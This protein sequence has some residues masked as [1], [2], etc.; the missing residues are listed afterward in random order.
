MLQRF[1]RNHISSAPICTS[2]LGYQSSRR[3]HLSK[4]HYDGSNVF[5]NSRVQS[6]AFRGKLF[7]RR[8]SGSKDDG[9]K[10]LEVKERHPTPDATLK[11]L[12]FFGTSPVVCCEETATVI[13]VFGTMNRVR[14]TALPAQNKSGTITGILT[15]RDIRMLTKETLSD[16]LLP[17]KDFL[18]KYRNE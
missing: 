5:T 9:C 13:D 4:W 8:R 18:K 15:I 7:F 11:E 6:D 16:L 17:V 1:K 3:V 12:G 2:N 10:Y 14:I